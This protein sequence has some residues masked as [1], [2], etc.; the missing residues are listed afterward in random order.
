MTEAPGVRILVVVN[1][2]SE[3]PVAHEVGFKVPEVLSIE[4]ADMLV[5]QG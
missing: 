2:V 1:E 5:G 4:Q 3:Y